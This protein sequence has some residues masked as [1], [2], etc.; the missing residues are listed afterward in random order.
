MCDPLAYFVDHH[1]NAIWDHINNYRQPVVVV[2]DSNKQNLGNGI[3]NSSGSLTLHYIVIRG[4][5]EDSSGIRYFLVYDPGYYSRNFEYTEDQLVYL[6]GMYGAPEW[7]YRYGKD[8][9]VPYGDMPA[10]MLTVYGD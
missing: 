9:I 3:R 1:P 5:K 2:V 10:Y 7:V 8:T 6:M 4:I